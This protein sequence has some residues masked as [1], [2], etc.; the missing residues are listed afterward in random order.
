MPD[1]S[2]PLPGSDFCWYDAPGRAPHWAP[3]PSP[4]DAVAEGGN[5]EMTDDVSWMK[6]VGLMRDEDPYYPLRMLDGT[7][8][9]RGP[10][11][12]PKDQ[13]TSYDRYTGLDDWRYDLA[14]R[15]QTELFRDE[16][17]REF[18]WRES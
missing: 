16:E 2:V 9:D 14:P 10:L 18:Y 7:G 11:A 4:A 15:R 8:P 1:P 6:S 12:Y 3:M 17:W 13:L 5:Y